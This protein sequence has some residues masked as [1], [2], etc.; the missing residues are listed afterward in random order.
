MIPDS[1]DRRKN[2]QR[3]YG[4]NI[5]VYTY[6]D[7]FEIIFDR[8]KNSFFFNVE[9]NYV[10]AKGCHLLFCNSK[11]LKTYFSDMK[12]IIYTVVNSRIFLFK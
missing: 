3:S 11:T 4:S 7:R 5:I 1:I 10:D 12:I 2:F 6:I 9:K 8:E